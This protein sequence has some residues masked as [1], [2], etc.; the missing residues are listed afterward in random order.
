MEA[1][2]KAIEIDSQYKE[3]YIGCGNAYRELKE[4]DKALDKYKAA[5]K[6][7][8]DYAEA[9]GNIAYI[10]GL[11]GK[12]EMAVEQYDKAL[13]L[14][15]DLKWARNNRKLMLNKLE[16]QKNDEAAVTLAE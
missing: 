10:Y 4:Y 16:K 3:A 6:L 5:L 7:D 1:Y 11:R 9:Y 15:P 13:E 12:Y 2:S 14:K 8:P